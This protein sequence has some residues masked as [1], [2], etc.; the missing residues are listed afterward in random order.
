[1]GQ[2]SSEVGGYIHY[3]VLVVGMVLGTKHYRDNVNGGYL[4]YGKCLGMGVMIGFFASLITS[5]YSYVFFTFIDPSIIQVMLD[6]AEQNMIDAGT[7]DEEIEL[8]MGYTKKFI[9]V[10]GSFLVW[11]KTLPKQPKISSFG[12]N[13]QTNRDIQRAANFF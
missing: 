12:E 1:M 5:F 8:A 7:S 10:P 9:F 4:N 13:G 6:Q 11:T 3:I 2:E